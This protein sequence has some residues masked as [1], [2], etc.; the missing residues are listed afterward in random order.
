VPAGPVIRIPFG[1]EMC[2]LEKISLFSIG[3]YI[4]SLI[5]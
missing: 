5:F 4:Y 2:K 1:G 3:R